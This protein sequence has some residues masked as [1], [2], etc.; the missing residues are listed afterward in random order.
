M[1]EIKLK[2]VREQLREMS[3][4]DLHKEIAAQRANLFD[5]RRK[6]AMRQIE[7]TAAIRNARKQIARALTILREREIAAQGEKK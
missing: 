3:D 1:A 2:Q 6:H 7:N 4:D 5:F